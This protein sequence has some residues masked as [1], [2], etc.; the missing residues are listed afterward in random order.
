M[1]ATRQN[2]ALPRH[3]LPRKEQLTAMFY[4]LPLDLQPDKPT[5]ETYTI[6][7]KSLRIDS[8]QRTAASY[9]AKMVLAIIERAILRAAG[10]VTPHAY[11][12]R[13][14]APSSLRLLATHK[15][16]LIDPYCSV[17]LNTMI[18]PPSER[19]VLFIFDLHPMMNGDV[20]YSLQAAGFN[21][22]P[23]GPARDWKVELV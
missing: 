1:S 10:D 19:P 6:G 22:E 5:L 3:T 15:A 20:L 7:T 18:I 2:T 17:A 9:V 13:P 14:P 16:E 21:P 12:F 8:S 4:A 11:L 23:Y